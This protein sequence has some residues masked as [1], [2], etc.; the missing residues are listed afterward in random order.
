MDFSPN[1]VSVPNDWERLWSLEERQKMSIK[2]REA[3]EKELEKIM[4][5]EFVHNTDEEP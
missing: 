1:I 3:F 2:D 4:N 5:V